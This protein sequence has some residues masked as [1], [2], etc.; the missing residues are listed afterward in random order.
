M[1]CMIASSVTG[2]TNFRDFRN[3]LSCKTLL[4]LKMYLRHQVEGFNQEEGPPSFQAQFTYTDFFYIQKSKT[5]GSKPVDLP[6]RAP[7]R[8]PWPK[9]FVYVRASAHVRTYVHTSIR[10]H[11]DM[12]ACIHT[13]M[14][15][16]MH[17]Q[18]R[19]CMHA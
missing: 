8:P 18:L 9:V 6:K 1:T 10:T 3:S 5:G 2:E 4:T 11:E 15:T 7:F 17:T 13:Y 12:H 16:Y 14:N 19:A